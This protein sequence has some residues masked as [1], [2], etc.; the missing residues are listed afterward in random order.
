[1]TVRDCP[2][3]KGSGRY[4]DEPCLCALLSDEGDTD[5]V[6]APLTELDDEPEGEP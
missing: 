5:P 4:D 2:L 3:C 1:M 6:P